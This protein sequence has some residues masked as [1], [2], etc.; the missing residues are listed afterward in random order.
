[1]DKLGPMCRSVEDCGIVLD[2]IYGP[3]GHDRSATRRVP[4]N[5]DA[6]LDWH[7]LRVGYL[8]NEFTRGP[9]PPP[10]L[11]PSVRTGGDTANATPEERE[12]RAEAER[13]REA[14]RLHA[15]YDRRFDDAAIERLKGMG[16][17]MRAVALPDLPW[18]AIS[19]LLEAEAAAAFD[20][21]TR[22]G[23]DKLLTSQGPSDW[24]TVFRA[25]RLIPAVEYIQANRAR[26]LGIEAMAKVFDGLDVIV[27][28]TSSTQLVVTNLTGHP[29]VIVP[30]GFRGTDAPPFDARQGYN[31][32]GGPGTPVSLTFIG[33]LYG[34]P[35]LLA[36]ARAYQEATG[37]HH[38]HP[39]L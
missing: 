34:E 36:F 15:E 30:N 20:E 22:T 5:W 25:A 38:E 35:K 9:Q 2:A 26:R 19:P 27:V 33:P 8:E 24:P 4:Y 17:T 18:R 29:A 32:Y 28:P 13:Q 7:T 16:V 12:Q 37:W 31:N 14:A 1:M 6:H 10:P 39:K 3:D 23:R 21:L 11:F